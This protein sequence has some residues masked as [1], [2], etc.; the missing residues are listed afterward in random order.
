M[1]HLLISD[2]YSPEMMMTEGE[3]AERPH[4]CRLTRTLLLTSYGLNMDAGVLFTVLLQH[5]GGRPFGN[6]STAAGQL[7]G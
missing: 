4:F 1:P 2:W 7:D 6:S 3:E 5:K